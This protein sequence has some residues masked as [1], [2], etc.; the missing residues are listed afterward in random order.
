MVFLNG[1]FLAHFGAFFCKTIW[2]YQIFFVTLQ[3]Q[4]DNLNRVSY[5]ATHTISDMR[6]TSTFRK[7]NVLAMTAINVP[8]ALLQEVKDDR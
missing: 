5:P 4:K 3:R 7:P 1:V 2:K 8:I 6:K